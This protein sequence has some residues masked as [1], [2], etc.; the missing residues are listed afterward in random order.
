MHRALEWFKKE[1]H[2]YI[3]TALFFSG[4]FSLIVLADRL[5]GRGSEVEIATFARAIVGGFIVGKI[6]LV[7]DLL[8]VV[9]RYPGKPLIYN[10]MW[11]TPIYVM[12][13]LLYRY[14]EPL[15]GSLIAGASI[16]VAHDLA[17]QE[18][19]Q[20]RF[21]AIEIWLA[22]LFV[23]FVTMHELNRALGKGKMRLMF[24]GR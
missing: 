11:K 13:S 21:W 17:V 15:I 22:I 6:L 3:E 5:V 9:D 2:E 4:T 7:V 23:I 1:F 20:S 8:P 18:F 16:A 24:F 10:I 14:V 12:V 19:T